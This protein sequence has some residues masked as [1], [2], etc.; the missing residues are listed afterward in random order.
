MKTKRN[1]Y[2][3]KKIVNI[4][5]KTNSWKYYPKVYSMH[6]WKN[7]FE[8]CKNDK[9][10]QPLWICPSDIFATA[11]WICNKE[12]FANFC[13]QIEST[14]I[15]S[16]DWQLNILRE[17]KNN[18]VKIGINCLNFGGCGL[19]HFLFF[20]ENYFSI[21][22]I[23]CIVCRSSINYLIFS[24]SKNMTIW[25]FMMEKLRLLQY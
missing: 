16:Y 22:I 17:F 19:S 13:L 25:L 7:F 5:F 3:K 23:C 4:V 15:N 24:W 10:N 6:L 1:I 12:F 11:S 21:V 20:F 18:N 14:K 9:A 2:A 8:K